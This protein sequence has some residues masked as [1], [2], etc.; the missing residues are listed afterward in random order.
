[1]SVRNAP[2]SHPRSKEHRRQIALVVNSILRGK[3]NAVRDV[4]LDTASATSTDIVDNIID[5]NTF[6]ILVPTTANAADWMDDI[7]QTVVEGTIT[8]E[9]PANTANDR[10]YRVL[11]VG[12]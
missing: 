8:L 11:L 5:T 9:H 12:E 7:Y 6:A 3:S 1:M 10:T 2:L 4:T